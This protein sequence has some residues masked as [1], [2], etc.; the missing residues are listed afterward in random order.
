MTE[1][2]IKERVVAGDVIQIDKATGNNGKINFF[3][4]I[5]EKSTRLVARL[6]N[7]KIMTHWVHK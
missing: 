6:P 7:P 1:S 5:K 4:K 3:I 2:V